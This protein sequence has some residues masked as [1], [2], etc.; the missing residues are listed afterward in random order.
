MD[1][2]ILHSS[3]HACHRKQKNF[4]SKIIS[5][6]QVLTKYEDKATIYEFYDQ[7]FDICGQQGITVNLDELD[8]SHHDLTD[9]ELEFSEDKVWNT[10]RICRL[11]KCQDMAMGL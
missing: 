6:E 4:I 7:I 1:M 11:T 10:S 9:I 2:Q 3:T 8:L 5:E